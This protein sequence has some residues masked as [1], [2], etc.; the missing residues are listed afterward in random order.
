MIVFF[1]FSFSQMTLCFKNNVNDLTTV[2]RVVFEGGEC[3]GEKS[4]S[5]MK[6]DGWIINDIQMKNNNFVYILKKEI[7]EKNLTTSIDYKQIAKELKNNEKKE[8]ESKFF[9]MGKKQYIQRCASCHGKKGELRTNNTSRPINQFDYEEMKNI[10][11]EYSKG[12]YN[13][14]MA[15]IMNPYATVLSHDELKAV[16]KY[17]DS[18]K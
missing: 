1:T 14:G 15:I 17:L 13:R 10:L 18:L 9:E 11:Y 5:D 3:K 6:K 4:I 7:K 2:E 12:R 8:I 16:V